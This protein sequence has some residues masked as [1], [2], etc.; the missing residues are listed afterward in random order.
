MESIDDE[1]LQQMVHDFIESESTS[2]SILPPNFCNSSSSKNHVHFR[3]STNYF[4][5]LQEIMKKKTPKERK[6][7]EKVEKHMR[8][9]KSTE[10]TTCL[11]QWIVKC[12]ILDGFHA[13]LCHISWNSC[14]SCPRGS[15]EYIEIVEEDA[16]GGEVRQIVDIE[17]K[18]Q[19]EIARPSESYKELLNKLPTI[20]V[21]KENDLN[22][23]ITLLCSASQES[24][25]DQGLH[26]PP[27]R[28]STYMKSKWNLSN[29]NNNNNNNNS[30]RRNNNNRAADPEII[31]GRMLLLC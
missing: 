26:V 10:N 25:R 28:K 31:W 21:G 18:S 1:K 4:L 30:S 6:I 22:T 23:I 7:E 11:K 9:K 17:F 3:H 16:N 13:S 8:N 15:Y 2:S 19:F 29:N 24:L 20:F 5:T 27:W 12:L 14:P